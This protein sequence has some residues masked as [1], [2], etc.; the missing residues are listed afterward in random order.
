MQGC[1]TNDQPGIVLSIAE[2]LDIRELGVGGNERGLS[3]PHVFEQQLQEG[4][5]RHGAL[6]DEHSAALQLRRRT[7]REEDDAAHWSVAGDRE[8]REEQVSLGVTR[9]L[10]G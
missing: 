10:D 2:L 9:V 6:A 7:L 3:V 5:T 1:I 4:N 8:V